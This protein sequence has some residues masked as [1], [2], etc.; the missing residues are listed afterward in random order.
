MVRGS[1]NMLPMTR[2]RLSTTIRPRGKRRASALLVM[3][4]S[5]GACGTDADTNVEAAASGASSSSAAGAGGTSTSTSTGGGG[6]QGGAAGSGGGSTTCAPGE[7]RACYSGPSGTQG[8]GTCIS[9]VETCDQGG[10]F[11]PCEGE[12]VPTFDDCLTSAD[13][14]C[15]VVAAA[16]TGNTE[17][18]RMLSGSVFD[19]E[20]AVAFLSG[21]ALVVTGSTTSFNFEPYPGNVLDADS[22]TTAN[23]FEVF[24]TRLTQTAGGVFGSLY[25]GLDDQLAYD[26]VVDAQDHV[27]ILGASA[28]SV[29][30]GDGPTAGPTLFLLELDSLGAFV[31]SWHVDYPAPAGEPRLA[32]AADGSVA[33]AGRFDGLAM[34]LDF[35]SGP[36]PDDLGTCWVAR[37]DPSRQLV[38]A[39]TMVLGSTSQVSL[40]V[41]FH[42]D[43]RLVV[44]GGYGGTLMADGAPVQ[45]A[46]NRGLV[47]AALDE[48]GGVDFL[49]VA[50]AAM[51]TEASV[52]VA[53]AGRIYIGGH[54]MNAAPGE[55]LVFPPTNASGEGFVASYA[56]TG[57]FEQAVV[58]P[59]VFVRDIAADPAGHVVATGEWEDGADFGGGS[60][61]PAV[62]LRDFFVAKFSSDGAPIWVNLATST[63]NIQKRLRSVAIAPDGS[64]AVAGWAGADVDFGNGPVTGKNL[65]SDIFV[66][67]FAP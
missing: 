46:P 63:Q 57:T 22:P 53:A 35:G 60:R 44:G 23:A 32:V 64:I 11:G 8:I 4:A 20:G 3:I 41:A 34:D 2:S 14:D 18:T 17:W 16:C 65:N 10:T 29:D 61:S 5:V 7:V 58:L 9:G 33:I 50:E 67:R 26:L 52:A 37:L 13:E 6:A 59:H 21:G 43:G 45:D 28:G 48:N 1:F 24:A 49:H 15:N 36:L 56:A 40:D 12:V 39:Q 31:S 47:I 30:F 27:H 38:F 51:F 54:G 55:G 25:G 66:G 42:P 62:S 19:N